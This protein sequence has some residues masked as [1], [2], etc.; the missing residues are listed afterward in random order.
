MFESL[1]G[2]SVNIINASQRCDC[3]NDLPCGPA[4]S[5]HSRAEDINSGITFS[6]NLCFREKKRLW[7]LICGTI[8]VTLYSGVNSLK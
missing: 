1:G 6:T 8:W 5:S 2:F 3:L 7:R 4:F